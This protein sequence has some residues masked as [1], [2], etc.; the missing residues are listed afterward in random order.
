M[1]IHIIQHV[2]FES[3][4]YLI[5]WIGQSNNF[6][7]VSRP[8][9]AEWYPAP[10]CFDLCIVLGGPMSAGDTQQFPWLGRELD[11]LEK[12]VMKRKKMLGICL[13]AQ[14]IARVLGGAVYQNLY[15]EIG[16]HPV[17]LTP[18]AR[19]L[20]M[21]ERFPESW[22]AFHW[23]QDTFAIPPMG[24]R[25]AETDG[26]SNQGFLYEDHVMA[27]QFHMESDVETVNALLRN[28]GGDL[29]LGSYIQTEEEIRAGLLLH[30]RAMHRLFGEW[31]DGWVRADGPVSSPLIGSRTAIPV[32]MDPL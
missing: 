9:E 31:L 24:Y 11:F 4:G 32:K 2:P 13:G 27:L 5:S 8:Y 12:A 14:L 16:W 10:D 17:R 22:T 1:K 15:R 23:H 19:S 30:L 26:C 3:P 29:A 7:T 20:P 28:C 18:A 25:I 21:F 6:V